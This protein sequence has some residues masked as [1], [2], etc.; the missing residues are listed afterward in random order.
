MGW[1]EVANATPGLQDASFLPPL[2]ILQPYCCFIFVDK[3]R[4]LKILVRLNLGLCG[5]LESSIFSCT[6][7]VHLIV[8]A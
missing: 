5:I 8:I 7:I 3:K 4:S 1:H 2:D 6:H